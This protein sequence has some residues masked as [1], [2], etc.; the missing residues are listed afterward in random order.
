M[1]KTGIY[2]TP[3]KAHGYT[4]V[5]LSLKKVG[6]L[7]KFFFVFGLFS[8]MVLELEL[9]RPQLNATSF[10]AFFIEVCLGV[11]DTTI[12]FPFPVV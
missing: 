6:I 10:S 4:T 9:V 11:G 3:V 7:S 12:S 8:S 5:F 2:Q 1:M